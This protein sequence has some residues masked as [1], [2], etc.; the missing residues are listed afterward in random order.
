MRLGRTLCILL[1]FLAPALLVGAGQLQH[2]TE[3]HAATS[4]ASTSSAEPASTTVAVEAR[5]VAEGVVFRDAYTLVGPRNFM[6]GYD[7]IVRESTVHAVIE[8]P[9]GCTDKWEVKTEDGLLHWDFKNGKPRKVSYLGYPCNYG[10]VPRTILGEERG[11]DGDPLDILVLGAALPR[12][13]VIEARVIGLFQMRDAGELDVKL[14]AVREDTPFASVRDVT[15]LE[16]QFPGAST[17]IET[18]FA[19]YKGPGVIE[20]AGFGGVARALEILRGAVQD[21]EAQHGGS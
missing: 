1:L 3:A 5:P 20:T 12:G 15:Q 9:A 2:G 6:S 14:V 17:I 10:M 7:A 19:H 4:P 8:I 18:W 13:S 11:G 21:Y 16:A